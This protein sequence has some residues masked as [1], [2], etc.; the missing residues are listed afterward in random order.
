MTGQIFRATL[1][2]DS[3]GN[4]MTNRVFFIHG[5]VEEMQ[6]NGFLSEQTLQSLSAV[7]YLLVVERASIPKEN[8]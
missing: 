3:R 2:V 5:A 4:T 6:S 7:E 8:N 1:F